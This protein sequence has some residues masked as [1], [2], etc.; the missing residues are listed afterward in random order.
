MKRLL[1]IAL[2]AAACSRPAPDA[3]ADYRPDDESFSATLPG[4]WKVDDSPAE[5]RKASFF[6]PPA[7]PAAFSEMI[8]VSL[9][10]GT[11]PEAYRA[12]RQGLPSPLKETEA[13]GAK[14]WEF[15]SDAEFRDPHA[16]VKKL[17]SR[18][19]AI[20][21]PKGLY[22]LEHSWPAGASA[23]RE[24]FEELLRTFKPKP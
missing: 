5:T 9:H 8:R 4:G 17:S 21:T 2:A 15:L 22:V 24:A 18:F 12:S 23:G 6:G 13:G 10:P 3:P 20:P 1:L 16:G 7:G 11:T 19:V 14:A